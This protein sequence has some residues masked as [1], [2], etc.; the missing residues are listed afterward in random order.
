MNVA[1]PVDAYLAMA[2]AEPSEIAGL[3]LTQ[4]LL[5]AERKKQTRRGESAPRRA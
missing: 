1:A 5:I 2:S 4:P 3:C